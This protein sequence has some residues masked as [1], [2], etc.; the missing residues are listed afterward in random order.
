MKQL[1]GVSVALIG[2]SLILCQ[3]GS[4]LPS[5]STWI[6]RWRLQRASCDS[7]VG[8]PIAPISNNGVWGVSEDSCVE[9]AALSF[10]QSQAS[11]ACRDPAFQDLLSSGSEVLQ[12]ISLTDQTEH[13]KSLSASGAMVPPWTQG[14]ISAGRPTYQKCPAWA[15]L[16]TWPYIPRMTQWV[17]NSSSQ[18]WS[19]ARGLE[20]VGLDSSHSLVMHL[21]GSLNESSHFVQGLA[22]NRCSGNTLCIGSQFYFTAWLGAASVAAW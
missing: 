8:W 20:S 9:K 13:Q 22:H 19:R 14:P 1:L 4:A 16:G 7:L 12:Q 21:W 15:T 3:P 11:T 2:N 17:G 10:E 5:L 18:P 6:Y